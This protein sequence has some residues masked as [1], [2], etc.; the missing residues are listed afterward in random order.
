V[1][2][3]PLDTNEKS[4]E[5]IPNFTNFYDRNSS[6]SYVTLSVNLDKIHSPDRYKV[7]FYTDSRKSNGN[8]IIDYTRW[9]AVPP[10]QLF[11]YM[12][13][14]SVEL[15]QG[16]TRNL[17][18]RLNSTEGYEPM[19]NLS[20][21]IPDKYII[22]T[23]EHTKS[24]N[25]SNFMIPSDGMGIVR[26]TINSA[27]NATLGPSI[28]IINATSRFPPEELLNVSGTQPVDPYN[29]ISRSSVSLLINKAPDW[30]DKISNIWD[31]IGGFTSFVFG[32]IIGISPFIY[33]Q[34]KKY[35]ANEKK[36]VK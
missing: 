21:K 30:L 27:D 22:P 16:E 18:L 1:K 8:L 12:T 35:F 34:I 6:G 9:V 32:A 11:S 17:I 20:A 5:N 3:G 7:I 26:L 10:L 31:K 36:E 33:T 19:V 15:T 25:I 4:I 14:N 28:L 24:S 23:F 29:V 13:P 2:W